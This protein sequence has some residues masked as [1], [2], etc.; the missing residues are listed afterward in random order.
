MFYDKEEDD[1]EV[2]SNEQVFKIIIIGDSGVGKTCLAHRFATGKFPERT[3]AT[4]GVD[5]WERKLDLNG[6]KIRL[7]IW[8]TAGQERF[9]KSMVVHY[10]RNVS[11]VIF[12]YDITREGSFK[13]LTTWLQEYEHFGFSDEGD[14]I[15]KLMIGNKCDLIH[16]R[17][18]SS[19]QARKFA[20]VHNMPVWEISTKNDEELETIE[21][22]F[23]TLSHK[24]VRSRSFM[25]RPT[26]LAN[27]DSYNDSITSKSGKSHKARHSQKRIKLKAGQHPDKKCCES[28]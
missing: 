6:S 1:N 19:N 10:Y 5:F 20:D 26:Y 23:L 9:R 7:Q 13:A 21:S 17:V 22:I 18:V 27:M 15:P 11:A 24:L 8:D 28:S 25:D 14:Q 16:E 2:E 12:M 3:E 4:I